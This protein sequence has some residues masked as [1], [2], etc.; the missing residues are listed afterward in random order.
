M[1]S[2]IPNSNIQ[3]VIGNWIFIGIIGIYWTLEIDR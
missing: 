2:Q 1:K 3:L